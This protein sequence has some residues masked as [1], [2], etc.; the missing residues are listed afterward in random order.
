[1]KSA[2]QGIY[3]QALNEV[4]KAGMEGI[5][6]ERKIYK[7]NEDE[8]KNFEKTFTEKGKKTT[9]SQDRFLEMVNRFNKNT[10]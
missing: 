9:K 6:D 3:W 10:V 4:R 1:M 2:I 8:L 7:I 5:F